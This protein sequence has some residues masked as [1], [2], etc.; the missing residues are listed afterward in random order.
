[1]Q[2]CKICMQPCRI[3]MQLCT[4]CT[5]L[6]TRLPLSLQHCRY[7]AG[8]GTR[9]AWRMTKEPKKRDGRITLR[10]AWGSGGAG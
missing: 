2:P 3:C 7:P 1:M 5:K 6:H 8:V 4:S 9:E 10:F